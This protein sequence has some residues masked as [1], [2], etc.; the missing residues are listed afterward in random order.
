MT[1]TGSPP[2]R[3]LALVP[4]WKAAGFIART[5]DALA[6]QTCRGLAFLI[7][8]D[9]SPD[10][11]AAICE[12]RAADDPRF[13]VIRQARNRG[14]VGNVNALLAEARADYL[15]FAFQDDLPEP[16]YVER[17]VAALEADP[18]AVLAFSDILLVRQD[19]GVE[20]RSYTRLEGVTDRIE[21]ARRIARL[22]GSWWIPNRGVFRASAAREIGGLR[23]HGAGEFSADWPW[24]LE[25]SL[26]GGF[27]RIPERLVTKIYV[28][29]SLS[30]TWRFGARQWAAATVS[31]M[32]AVSRRRL[33]LRH[34][35]R[36]HATLAGFAL[37]QFRRS[38]RRRLTG[39]NDR[40]P[41]KAIGA[42]GGSQTP[43]LVSV[44]V[45]VHDR[46]D[47]AARAI[48]SVSS[49]THR[50]LELIVV[51]DASTSAFAL[52]PEAFDLEARLV[53]LDSNRGPGTA[54]DAGRRIAKGAYIAY[55]DS[56]DFW[57]PT[58]LASLVAALSAAPEAG[59][60]YSATMEMREGRPSGLRRW[61]DEAYTEILPTLL[62]RRPWHTSS[63]VWRR[64]LVEAM[65]GWGPTWH[66]EDHEHDCRAGCLGAK[67]IY[68]PEPTC[69]VDV[70]SP[71]RQ[72]ASSAARR[73][74]E[75]YG[76]AMLSMARRIRGTAWHRDPIVRN[77][78]REILLTAAARAAEQKLGVL[79]ARA[80]MESW[81]WPS[82]SASLVV[83]SA[84]A[85]PLVWL[86]GGSLSAR[87]FRWAR[88]RSAGE[89]SPPSAAY[90]SPPHGLRPE[91]P[92]AQ[93]LGEVKERI[94]RG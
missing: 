16:D 26:L 78:V 2:P 39:A 75:S 61:N 18:S 55:L 22:Q 76:L 48:R 85:V 11:T 70:D 81:R 69:F 13:R 92:N 43:S 66:W 29:G 9:A 3:V 12:R 77:R 28:P 7:S 25:M 44:I 41:R 59:M 64:D 21:R 42:R 83:A 52:P 88:R 79:A 93:R 94:G 47:L 56:D 27:V 45:P 33:P 37:R 74:I 80:A 23:R 6:A 65:G 91:E 10:D 84:V 46:F 60:A 31:A 5:L 87:I 71:G 8:D 57:A 82:P 68:R 53:R 67:L 49:Q 24:L 38:A 35:I 32:T 72:S 89:G 40:D 58:H 36:L 86:T 4:T 17:C 14:W 54:R 1:D 90:R 20:E 34:A 30:R 51:D 50:P 73:R 15:L 62:W 19:G 63:C